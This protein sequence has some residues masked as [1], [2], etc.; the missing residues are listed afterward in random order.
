MN[1]PMKKYLNI[2]ATAIFPFLM[3]ACD[4]DNKTAGIDPTAGG[5]SVMLINGKQLTNVGPLCFNYD[6]NGAL[7][8]MGVE[9]DIVTVKHNPFHYSYKSEDGREGLTCKFNA[10]GFVSSSSYEDYGPDGKMICTSNLSYSYNDND[11]ISKVSGKLKISEKELELSNSNNLIPITITVRYDY[12][13]MLLEQVEYDMIYHVGTTTVSSIQ[14]L[15]LSYNNSNLNKFNQYS[16]TL[17][18]VCLDEY[19]GIEV[20]PWIGLMGKASSHFPTG[21]IWYVNDQKHGS[22][23]SSVY[24]NNDGTIRYEQATAYDANGYYSDRIDY[25][26]GYSD[27]GYSSSTRATSAEHSV[28]KMR[29]HSFIRNMIQQSLAAE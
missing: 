1:T 15:I 8:S 11:Q 12:D 4:E 17:F 21:W 6:S 28:H 7:V 25:D 9:D 26:F 19:F 2:M 23:R 3:F 24:L 22:L 14:K 29:A 27:P 5:N 10:N 20:L 13:G 18:D 16:W